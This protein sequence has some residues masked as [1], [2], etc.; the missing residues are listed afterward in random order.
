MARLVAAWAVRE[1]VSLRD[2]VMILPFAQ[3]LPLARRAFAASGGWMPR[4][5]TTQTLAAS[6][7]PPSP[8]ASGQIS[9]DV[10][11]D[12]LVARQTLVRQA[13]AA[14]WARRDR[15]GFERAAERVVTTTHALVR[16][17]AGVAPAERAAWL[18]RAGEALPVPAGPG[19]RERLLARVAVEWARRAPPPPT[20]RLFDL[21]PAGWVVVE[22]GGEDP[23][24]ASLLEETAAPALV[25]VADP[26]PAEPFADIA[27][28]PPAFA[29]CDSFEDEAAAAA[30][31]VL[32]HLGRG[33]RPVAL[34]AQDR[35]LIRRIRA[36]LDREGVV[37]RDETGWKLSTT[38]AGASLMSLLV[39]ARPGA[40]TDSVLDWLKA[41]R[42]GG[43]R[44]GPLGR[45]EAA[46]RRWQVSGVAGL[47]GLDL[48]PEPAAL[49]DAALRELSSL[50]AAPRR[51]LPAWLQVTTQALYRTGVLAAL[52]A[53]PAGS[54]AL[55]ALAIEPPMAPARQLLLE[56]D[57]E[58][59]G[60]A[61]FSRWVDEVLDRQTY[62]PPDSRPDA[63]RDSDRDFDRDS[64]PIDVVVTPLVRAMLRPF[65]AVV[66]PGADAQ[67]LGATA[68]VDSL[69]GL[70]VAERLGLPT[71][72]GLRHAE[73]LA[74]AQV[75]RLPRTK[76]LR[77]RADGA[78]PLADSPLVEQLRLALAERGAALRDWHDPR[79]TL[80]VPV[81][82]VRRSAPVVDASRL[83]TRLSASA[84]EALRACP[85][86][87][88]ARSVLRLREDDE[89]DLEV[90]KRDYGSWLHDV[91][92]EFHAGFGDA[93]ATSREARIAR[94]LALGEAGRSRA[95]IAAA[96]FLPFA[97]SFAAFAPRYVDWLAAREASGARWSQGEVELSIA[98]PELEGVE[99]VGRVDRI[100]E[101][102]FEG[103]AGSL[104]LVDYKT[105]SASALKEKLRDRYEDTQLAFYA[106]LVGAGTDRP[107]TASY[108]AL[109][110]T[111]GLEEIVHD[112]VGRS[113]AAVVAG[114]AGELRRLRGGEAMRPLG[115][116]STCSHCEARGLCRRD[117]WTEEPRP[118]ALEPAGAPAPSA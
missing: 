66:L 73:R 86:R 50:T 11:L 9:F 62:L 35:S 44:P 109:D 108:L 95:G 48:E 70:E 7:G 30:A 112:E 117:H 60:F 22:A 99:L 97:A 12:T 89:L 77:R 81:A 92:Y 98:P 17:A 29:E 1:N 13:W 110:A 84:Y 8:L 33:E 68:F 36:L 93:A 26:D 32:D 118:D 79:I 52:R 34:I 85:Y 23:L 53:D 78:E 65:A 74:F 96:D 105:G 116:G 111:A 76:L 100:D 67:H 104:H 82:A 113:A 25:L 57:L 40:T 38:R 31:Q 64:L 61:E 10:P 14:E 16:A 47:A 94:L 80:Q 56:A 107:L 102:G 83:P 87:F 58:P 63:A 24:L 18:Q 101:I 3:L 115:E 71:P 114:V 28:P 43:E 72:A 6:L 15:R 27:S 5:E 19:A 88:F 42:L 46:C 90:D 2:C 45:L 91:L 59:M 54:Q 37:L 20:D 49:R 103:G 21:A 51:A 55:A 4:V 39:A 75:L 106:A 41:T 69:V